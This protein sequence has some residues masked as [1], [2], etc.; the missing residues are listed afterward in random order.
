MEELY[1]LHLQK[2]YYGGFLLLRM[3]K[4][5]EG[6]SNTERSKNN[7]YQRVYAELRGA[8]FL[9]WPAEGCS[10][11]DEAIESLKHTKASSLNLRQAIIDGVSGRRGNKPSTTSTSSLSFRILHGLGGLDEWEVRAPNSTAIEEWIGGFGRAQRELALLEKHWTSH[12]INNRLR[13]AAANCF[14]PDPPILQVGWTGSRGVWVDC[15]VGTVVK[16]G[17]G[18]RDRRIY[19][20]AIQPKGRKA[21]KPKRMAKLKNITAVYGLR[22]NHLDSDS[23]DFVIEGTGQLCS[24]PPAFSKSKKGLPPCSPLTLFRVPSSSLQLEWVQALNGF[25]QLATTALMVNHPGK[26]RPSP[27]PTTT[28][29]KTMSSTSL[30]T[31]DESFVSPRYKHSSGALKATTSDRNTQARL[32]GMCNGGG[33][34]GGDYRIPE[35]AAVDYNSGG[36]KPWESSSSA[37]MMARHVGKDQP[38]QSP[39]YPMASPMIDPMGYPMVNSM[40]MPTMPFAPYM[41]HMMIPTTT[42]NANH[43]QHYQPH[44]HPFYNPSY[45]YYLRKQ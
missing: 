25:L 14:L 8:R 28:T 9:Y 11:D 40:M 39:P 18:G 16:G 21:S 27:S 33:G 30:I 1:R 43:Q 7:T 2:Y 45:S 20:F 44:Y 36:R 5:D 22:P 35:A 37:L 34:S 29:I 42:T 31:S 26:T 3:L 15:L 41:Q 10:V 23:F 13:V 24:Q 4:D 6:L 19:L 38:Q 17:V 12:Q 32:G